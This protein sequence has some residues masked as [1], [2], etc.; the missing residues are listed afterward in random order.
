MATR[1]LLAEL[2]CVVVGKMTL[3]PLVSDLLGEDGV[4]TDPK[5]RML[6]QLPK[7]LTEMEWLAVAVANQ[8]AAAG[9]P[10]F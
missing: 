2:G 6:G 3:L 5:H 10:V 1:P 4:P 7:M 9:M 8:R